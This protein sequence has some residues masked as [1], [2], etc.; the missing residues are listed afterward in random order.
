MPGAAIL[1][2]AVREDFTDELISEWRVEKGER[3]RSNT[4]M[5]GSLFQAKEGRGGHLVG[6][7][8]VRGKEEI[9]SS[10]GWVAGREITH[11]RGRATG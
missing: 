7:E 5:W 3:G 11:Q 8:S 10:K 6:M 4:T 9:R 2:G 1:R